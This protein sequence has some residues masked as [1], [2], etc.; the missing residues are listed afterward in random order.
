M[1]RFALGFL[2]FVVGGFGIQAAEPWTQF[3]GPRGN[4]HGEILRLT[5]R[6]DWQKNLLWSVKVPGKGWSSPVF[7]ENRVYLTTAV[8]VEGTNP[9]DQELRVLAL[10]CN[11]GK[12]IWNTKV[13]TQNGASAP[14]IHSKNSHAS[15][16]L[17]L[18][19]G[20]IFAH[21]GHMGTA[22]L[23]MDGAIVWRSPGLY[24]KPVHGGGGS[25]LLVDDLLIFSAD[26]VDL[27]AVVALKQADG[28]LAWKTER[29][30]NPSRPF[31]FSTPTLVARKGSRFILSPGSDVVMA[32]EP[33]TGKEL[34]RVPYKGY[35]VIP[36]PGIHGNLA[37]VSTS[38]DNASLLA[39]KLDATP[40]GGEEAIAWKLTKAAP[41]T[42]SPLVVGDLLF[43]VS[44]NGIATCLDP[45][46]GKVHWQERLGRAYSASPWHEPGEK[47][48]VVWFQSETG[49]VHQIRASATF[50]KIARWDLKEKA[51]ATH[52]PHRGD[53]YIRTETQ[54]HK[55]GTKSPQ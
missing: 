15:P 14:K 20:R 48:G 32:L 1:V 37:F 45:Q 53:L 36:R 33:A 44:D 19:N 47:G 35:S 52:G 16:T 24:Q 18:A 46:T 5:D 7:L 43:V 12:V 17:S 31:S 22:C 3:L 49:E 34:W 50:E 55:L 30:A 11:N 2:A 51:L 13:L 21:F 9:P 23:D 27:Q 28:K 26:A 54:L 6:N 38:Y 25:P 10:D 39:V 42:P 8:P 29:N 4:A 41:H 40:Q